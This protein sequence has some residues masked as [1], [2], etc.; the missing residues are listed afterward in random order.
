MFKPKLLT[1]LRG[2]TRAQFIN[3]LTAGLIVGVVALPLAIAFAIASGVSPEKGLITS[4]IAG[5]LISALGGSRV[6]IGGPT[7]AFVVIIYGIVQKYGEGGLVIACMIAGVLLIVM[8]L[9]R[10]G[11]IIKFIPH[12]VI[13]GFTSGIAVIIFSSQIKDA[14]GL[15]MGTVPSE[16]IAKWGAYFEHL[17]SINP[18]SVAVTA[19]S[20]LII[21]LWPRVSHRIPGPLIALIAATAAVHLLHLDVE[22]IGS[23]FGSIPST[24]PTPT[25]PALSFETLRSLFNPALTIALLAAIES[26]LSAVVADGMIG[27][28]HRSN[29]ELIGQGIANLVTPLFGGIPATGAIART[30]TNIRNG[31]RTPVAGMVH[32][33]VLLLIMLFLGQ[34]AALIPL[35][36]LAAI[37]MVVAYNMS[38]WRSF[39]SMLKSPMSDVIVLVL[40]FLLT[41]IIDLTVAIEV[42]LALSMLLF[43]R[44]MAMV[45]NVGVI[46]RELQD[47]EADDEELLSPES[48][49]PGIDIYEINGPLFFGA[50]SKFE[51][52][53]HVVETQPIVRILRMRNVPAIDAT[54]LHAIEESAQRL[55]RQGAHLLI[56][57]IH[58][59]PLIALERSEID[60]TIG[61]ENILPTLEE[62]LVRA[63]EIVAAEE[64]AAT[65]SPTTQ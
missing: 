20:L 19:G 18:A 33:V 49:P 23:R 50:A 63:R 46:T 32:A 35:P 45:T 29:T 6:Q 42:G 2:Y 22:T 27:G 13:V 60:S 15:D 57:E 53:M 14:L 16:F 61:P 26:L 51:E 56:A 52:A 17:A 59:Q 11:S 64:A 47:D 30:A 7:G 21:I 28:R 25:I 40:T 8:G 55:R 31:G 12:P 48:I 43:M 24:L 37:L 3:D 44:R 4:I 5:F 62:A 38:E 65:P 10:F 1:T 58:A 34:W 41:V 54:G 9:A 39:R 36:C